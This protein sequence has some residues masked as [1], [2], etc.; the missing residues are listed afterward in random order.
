MHQCH[1]IGD[2]KKRNRT[3]Y[4]YFDASMKF[5]KLKKLYLRQNKIELLMFR[6]LDSL[7][8]ITPK[9]THLYLSENYL[10]AINL[11]SLSPTLTHLY[12]DNNNI[13]QL[14]IESSNNSFKVLNINGNQFN[15][16]CGH[17]P[18]GGCDGILLEKFPQLEYFSIEN[19]G[20][21]NVSA[22]AFLYSSALVYLIM[23]QNNLSQIENR[24]FH[25]L[26]NLKTLILD[27]NQLSA[28][29]DLSKLKNLELFSIAR[30]KISSLRKFDF[31]KLENLKSLNLS[32]NLD[33]I[34]PGTFNGF[35]SLEVLDLSGNKLQT[36]STFWITPKT[37]LECLFLRN[38]L[39]LSFSNL[40]LTAIKNLRYVSLAENPLPSIAN[41]KSLMFLSDNVT[42]DIN[43]DQLIGDTT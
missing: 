39:F 14:T 20:L 11:D 24:T 33:E 27:D 6:N 15:E 22:N 31:D 21:R 4:I 30:N 29:P 3:S 18:G 28:L 2:Y 16:L 23:S 41:T 42:L 12:L 25:E 9:L 5:P 40:P 8:Q 35:E 37:K 38:N 10:T 43:G 26:V 13:S 7:N 17:Y 19:V 34:I 36:L 32:Y 1:K